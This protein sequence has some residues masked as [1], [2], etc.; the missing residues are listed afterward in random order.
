MPVSGGGIGIP[1]VE[2]HRR[3]PFP[4]RHVVWFA[5]VTGKGPPEDHHASLWAEPTGMGPRRSDAGDVCGEEGDGVSVE[6][7]RGRNLDVTPG[8][9]RVQGVGDR[10]LP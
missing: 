10:G 5:V 2:Y 9:A 7:C 3:I 6:V 8:D 4:A 1:P